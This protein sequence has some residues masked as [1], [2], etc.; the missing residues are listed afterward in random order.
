MDGHHDTVRHLVR[1]SLQH[2]IEGSGKTDP[3]TQFLIGSL[4]GRQALRLCV[5]AV[6]S[7]SLLPTIDNAPARYALTEMR[8][9][10]C[11]RRAGVAHAPASPR[12]I[13][14]PGRS[15]AEA[16]ARA[17]RRGPSV[18][19]C[20][21]A[22]RGGSRAAWPDRSYPGGT[23][24]ADSGHGRAVPASISVG[25]S[26]WSPRTATSPRPRAWPWSRRAVPRR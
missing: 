6:N 24:R 9:S 17:H 3:H 13:R 20:L 11:P 18:R 14:T 22:G 25:S 21:T 23:A 7:E 5:S 16:A 26:W 8:G 19:R 10:M 4:T 12:Q 15:S 1:R 2:R